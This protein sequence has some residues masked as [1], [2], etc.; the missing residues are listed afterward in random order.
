MLICNNYIIKLYKYI[1]SCVIYID[2]VCKNLNELELLEFDKLKYL[3][4]I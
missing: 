2:V 3:F 1:D 4:Y